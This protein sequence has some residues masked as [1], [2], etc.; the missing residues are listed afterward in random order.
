MRSILPKIFAIL[1]II[2]LVTSDGLSEICENYMIIRNSFPDGF[3][4]ELNL[5]VMVQKNGWK[6]I[7][8]FDKNVTV[9]DVPNA[10]ILDGKTSK[11]KFILENLQH[12]KVMNATS[13]FDFEFT[14]H[15]PRLMYPKPKLKSV[16]FDPF[17]CDSNFT[18][19]AKI[20]D[21][22]AQLQADNFVIPNCW[23]S[24][25]KPDV[26]PDGYRG[27][28]SIPVSE[29]TSMWELHIEYDRPIFFM[30]IWQGDVVKRVNRTLFIIKSKD[31]TGTLKRN[32]IFKFGLTVR[33]DRRKLPKPELALVKFRDDR[34]QHLVCANA[35]VAALFIE[36]CKPKPTIPPIPSR[37]AFVV[38]MDPWADGFRGYLKIPIKKREKMWEAEVQF[39]RPI[40]TFDVWE[41]DVVDKRAMTHF[42]MKNKSYLPALQPGKIFKLG[43]A[44]HHSRSMKPKPNV[45]LIKF[46]D[47]IICRA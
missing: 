6:I 4:A 39:S 7:M 24:L 9:L 43:F 41:V 22:C 35:E 3:R 45:V 15:Y 38:V 37:K 13:T 27:R 16:H 36:A 12:N 33:Y 11:A 17:V 21:L 32:S 40:L 26:W 23:R 19:A 47:H 10:N 42:K 28:L 34:K 1:N 44:I 18:D 29:D 25:R 5:P 30:D 8:E 31:Y 46:G 2:L 14:V 20:S